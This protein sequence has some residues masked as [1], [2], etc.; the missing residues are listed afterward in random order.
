MLYDPVFGRVEDVD[1][2]YGNLSARDICQQWPRI[3]NDGQIVGAQNDFRRTYASGE[4]ILSAL[5]DDLLERTFDFLGVGDDAMVV[6]LQEVTYSCHNPKHN[7]DIP[8]HVS[9]KGKEGRRK[10]RAQ[11]KKVYNPRDVAVALFR[12]DVPLSEATPTQRDLLYIPFDTSKGEYFPVHNILDSEGNVKCP[13]CK[14]KTGI[15]REAT[16]DVVVFYRNKLPIETIIDLIGERNDPVDLRRILSP[17]KIY[18]TYMHGLRGDIPLEV[19][20]REDIPRGRIRSKE[21]EETRNVIRTLCAPEGVLQSRLKLTKLVPK[22]LLTKDIDQKRD[23][24]DFMGMRLSLNSVR[25]VY[26]V[27]HG[28]IRNAPYLAIGTTPDDIQDYISHPK[29]NGYQ[30]L[31]V[32]ARLIKDQLPESI[33]DNIPEAELMKWVAWKFL[34]IQ[35]RT[36]EMDGM[37]H[38]D[39]KQRHDTY[40][41]MRTHQE[42]TRALKSKTKKAKSLARR[43]VLLEK[44]LDHTQIA[45]E[46]Y[47]P[48]IHA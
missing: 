9:V 41:E 19:L 31:Q 27:F 39:S 11:P 46:R 34:E 6:N 7:L 48:N 12:N 32:M 14:S 10:K 21:L 15:S 23:M 47:Y 8:R 4:K 22:Y 24:L 35:L 13:Y 1:L 44:V 20:L 30:T 29:T 38:T 3:S 40:H 17:F 42:L 25:E 28:L 37:A 45:P 5:V 36:F 43:K 16:S 26:G 33:K 18:Q 2:K